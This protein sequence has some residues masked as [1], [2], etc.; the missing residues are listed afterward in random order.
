MEYIWGESPL[1]CAANNTKFIAAVKILRDIAKEALSISKTG[2]NSTA[3]KFYADALS[4]QFP[5]QNRAAQTEIDYDSL[6]EGPLSNDFEYLFEKMVGILREIMQE[7]VD[8]DYDFDRKD[9]QDRLL[10]AIDTSLD[11]LTLY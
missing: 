1:F 3:K 5:T 11:L 4:A 2:S 7:E 10:K 9:F 8:Y 6:I